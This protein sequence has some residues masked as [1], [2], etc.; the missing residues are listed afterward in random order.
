MAFYFFLKKFEYKKVD[1]ESSYKFSASS[2]FLFIT[3]KHTRRLI[4]LH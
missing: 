4:H 1:L 2:F 3:N